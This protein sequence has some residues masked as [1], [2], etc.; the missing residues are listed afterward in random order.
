MRYAVAFGLS[1][2]ALTLG[3]VMSFRQISR[4]AIARDSLILPTADTLGGDAIVAPVMPGRAEYARFDSVDRAWRAEHA[5]AYTLAELRA[6]GDGRRTPRELMEDRVYDYT[7]RG[8]RAQAIAELE[9]WV[10]SNPRDR[11]AV[12]SLARLLN[13]SG[14]TNEAI[15]RYR[16]LLGTPAGGE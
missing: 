11:D 14:R 13:E 1:A 7:R 8:A 15:A 4:N 6:R 16:Q 12:L 3:T 10:R 2:L 9:R 5:H